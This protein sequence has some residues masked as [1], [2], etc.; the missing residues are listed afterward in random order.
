MSLSYQYAC[1]CHRLVENFDVRE[2]DDA[3]FFLQAPTRTVHWA[4]TWTMRGF[5]LEENVWIVEQPYFV[6]W[7]AGQFHKARGVTSQSYP[8]FVLETLYR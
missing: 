6:V 7:L 5:L 8:G 2:L 4:S 1:C 3:C